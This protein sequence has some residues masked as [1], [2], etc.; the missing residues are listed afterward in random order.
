M[1]NKNKQEVDSYKIEENQHSGLELEIHFMPHFFDENGCGTMPPHI[2][3]F[4]QI[5]W[6]RFGK[7]SHR[8]DFVDYPITDNTIFFI[9][10][11]QI[12]AF[13]GKKDAEGVIILFNE[14]FLM[15]E[16]SSENLFLKYNLF[17]TCD[18]VPYYKV[19]E[20]ETGPLMH[21][22][23]EMNR[24][25]AQNQAFAHKDYMQ[26]LVRLFLI[27]VQRCGE[28]NEQ[29]K[30]SISND[31]DRTVIGFRKLIEHNYPTLHT[32]QEYAD[33]LHISARTL[34]H[35]VVERTHHTPLQL[36]NDRIIL[37]AKRELLYTSLSIK[38]IG[39]ELGF[40]DASYFVKFFK[41][42]VGCTPNEFRAT[43]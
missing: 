29:P 20:E 3:E 4:Y 11:G 1:K 18:S 31:A 25:Y 2:H 42:M 32:V 21:L 43:K 27:R 39:Y 36:I 9:A 24:E 41:R 17:N 12:H 10:P 5:L 38:E 23:Q 30:L 16:H 6:Y 22:V 8:V 26:Y 13:D 37:E 34:T 15:D 33:L 35:Y 14:S 7:G 28:R 40:D 19:P